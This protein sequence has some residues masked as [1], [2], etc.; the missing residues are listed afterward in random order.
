[1]KLYLCISKQ[2][3][4]HILGAFACVI[5]AGGIL[6]CGLKI[7]THSIH[8][9]PA[10]AA[11]SYE[12]GLSFQTEHEP[13]VPNLSAEELRPYDAFYCGDPKQKRL[14]LT[15]DAGYEN[16]N[17]APILDALKKH[18]APGAFFVVSNYVKENPDLVKRMVDEGHLVGNHTY[19]HPDMSKKSE[20]EFKKELNDL[21]ALFEETT[22]KPLP[23]FYRPPEGKF[24]DENLKWAK[25]LGY[26]TVFWSLAYVDWNPESQPTHETAF[27]KL[28]PRTHDGAIV[29]LHS[30]SKTNAEILDE[31]LTK[32][33]EMGYSFG[34]LTELGEIP[35]VCQE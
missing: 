17:T 26:K 4:R 24:S 10:V 35:P 30:T 2:T 12:W 14:Y 6:A 23:R 7:R 29:L 5:A 18:N 16:G 13:P 27:S 28:I 34:S 11:A 31:L 3:A 1:M 19:H 9:V 8:D 22:G 25:S 15:F 20:A 32:W 33:E 21:A